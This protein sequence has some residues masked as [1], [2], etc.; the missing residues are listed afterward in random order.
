MLANYAITQLLIILYQKA[1][2]HELTL[3]LPVYVIERRW[4]RQ[5]QGERS[6]T[7]SS[8]VCR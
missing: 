4:L 3:S 5:N 7:L 6:S 8:Q 1:F 2:H